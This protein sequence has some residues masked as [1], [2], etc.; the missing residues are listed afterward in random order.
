MQTTVG[1]KGFILKALFQLQL[2]LA[3]RHITMKLYVLIWYNG[4]TMGFNP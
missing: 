3:E 4:G 2:K 1:S